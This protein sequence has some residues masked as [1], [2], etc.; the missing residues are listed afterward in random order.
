[1]NES[2][3]P[4]DILF[5]P[6]RKPNFFWSVHHYF[7]EYT[8]DCSEDTK[9]DYI[10]RYKRYIFP[11]VNPSLF[12]GDYDEEELQKLM[13][14]IRNR[15][16]YS[17]VSIET[18][19]NHLVFDPCEYWYRDAGNH[20]LDKLWGSS[21]DFHPEHEADPDEVLWR[22][23][24]S[25]TPQ[26]ELRALKILSKVEENPGEYMG[27]LLMFFTAVR[28]NEACAIN[29]GSFHALENH[30]DVSCMEVVA[31]TMLG[32]NRLKAS[33][34]THN[35]PRLLPILP[36]LKEL[37]ERRKEFVK[38]QLTF[39]CTDSKGH[40][41]A[42][43][44]ELPVACRGDR[45]T[46]RCSSADLSNAGREFLRKEV[47]LREKEV[48]ALSWYMQQVKGTNEDPDEKDVTTYLLRRNMATHLYTCEFSVTD[49]QY[50]MG[51]QM[52]STELRRSD[53]MDNAYLY[54]LYRKLLQHPLCPSEAD[55]VIHLDPDSASADI[56]DQV[57]A[58]ITIPQRIRSP[59]L[60]R[61]TTKDAAD[62]LQITVSGS[63]RPV[64]A[65]ILPVDGLPSDINISKYNRSRY[66][67][68]AATGL[69]S[70]HVNEE[71]EKKNNG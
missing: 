14:R 17:D 26:E 31:S 62:P 2:F 63:A 41:F 25:L 55:P 52:D 58:V 13:E 47:R 38:S 32:S 27:L 9:D 20:S 66:G 61:I 70:C 59:V 30:P 23:P 22:I 8:R 4:N 46:T 11:Y 33:G 6:D 50:Y 49:S 36:I 64:K 5:T 42:S 16:G 18:G 28:N 71:K 69:S 24:R 57:H 40:V 56:M 35:A 15:S 48:S 67:S 19:L 54:G 53:F 21:Y 37:L 12:A 3:S 34:K 45:C 65:V 29:F 7:A 68:P 43:V 60:V 51:H 10:K 44:E 39:P 1:M